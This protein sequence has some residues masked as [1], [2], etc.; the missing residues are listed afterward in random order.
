[1]DRTEYSEGVGARTDGPRPASGSQ[2]KLSPIILWV[3]LAAALFRIVTTVTDKEK[4]GTGA[5]LV[6]WMAPEG[7]V[8]AARS[9]GK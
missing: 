9:S 2:S 7:A 1:M 5:G 3:L 6:K 8:A 4:G